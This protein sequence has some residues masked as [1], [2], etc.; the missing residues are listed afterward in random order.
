MVNHFCADTGSSPEHQPVMTKEREPT[1]KPEP[2]Q[3]QGGRAQGQAAR[4]RRGSPDRGR[5]GVG[6]YTVL[7]SLSAQ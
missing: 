6:D 4:G 7:A 5:G 2:V 1:T 3:N